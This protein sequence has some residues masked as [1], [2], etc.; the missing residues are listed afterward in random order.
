MTRKAEMNND[1]H[2][3]L[4]N[5]PPPQQGLYDPRFEHE[6]CGVGFVVNIK[7]RKSHSIIEQALQVLVR[8]RDRLNAVAANAA[9]WA[10]AAARN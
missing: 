4:R 9:P 8:E 6:A 5:G 7:G 3:V 2:R 10:L 1:A